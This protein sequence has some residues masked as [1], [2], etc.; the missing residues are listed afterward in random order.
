MLNFKYDVDLVPYTTFWVKAKARI[1]VEI[2]S[3]ESFL[4]LIKANEWKNNEHLFLGNWANILFRKDF[5][6]LVVKVNIK[7]KKVINNWW[8][9][10]YVEAGSGED[11]NDFVQWTIDRWF[12]GIENMI[13]IPSSVGAA[14]FWNIWAYGMEAKDRILSVHG[15]DTI[16]WEIITLPNNEC[17]FWYRDSIFKQKGDFFI[18][19]VTFELDVYDENY[20]L[21]TNYRDIKQYIENN[22]RNIDIKELA[23]AITEI[24]TKKLPDRKSLGTA[25]SFFKNP[26]ISRERLWFLKTTFYNIACFDIPW[27]PAYVKLSAWQLIEL[28]WFKWYKKWNV[29][30]YDKHALILINYGWATGREIIDLAGEIQDKVQKMFWVF[31]S[32]EVIYI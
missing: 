4:R 17:N 26:I 21:N 32:P 2:E 7:G 19:K 10:V 15:I 1:F 28:A 5:D 9:H 13:A 8:N 6:G 11:R 22:W 23:K 24:R 14:A 16:T 25:W 20:E 27:D 18:T 31:L 30:V 3:E 12:A 29:G